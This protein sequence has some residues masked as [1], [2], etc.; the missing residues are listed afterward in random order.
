[1]LRCERLTV[2]RVGLLGGGAGV[3]CGPGCGYELGVLCGGDLA[4][5]VAIAPQP[6]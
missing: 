1:L 6:E 3:E 5:V 4:T 2:P